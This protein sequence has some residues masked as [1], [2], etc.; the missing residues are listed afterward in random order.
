MERMFIKRRKILI[1]IESKFV[2]LVKA[3]EQNRTQKLKAKAPG[4]GRK[5]RFPKAEKQLQDEFFKM[6]SEGK[7]VKRW[8]FSARAR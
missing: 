5:A 7:A 6:R 2:T 1:C 3:E 8:R 4:R